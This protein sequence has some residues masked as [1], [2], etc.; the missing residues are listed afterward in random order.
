M[1]V[2]PVWGSPGRRGRELLP[3]TPVVSVTDETAAVVQT[4]LA[5]GRRRLRVVTEVDTA[6]RRTPLLL[7]HLD[8]GAEDFVLLSGHLDSWHRGAMDNGSA[9]AT[10]MEV[11]RVLAGRREALPRGLLVAFWSGHSHGRY[12]GSAW[13]ADERCAELSTRCVAHVNVDSVGGRGATQI[14]RGV[15]TAALRGLGAAVIRELTGDE[16]TGTRVGRAG[17]QSFL[18]HG[19]PSLWMSL[20]EQPDGGLGWWWH[21]TEDT[22]DK[23]DPDLLLRDARI[24]AL[25]VARLVTCP[26]LPLDAAA[27]AGEVADR[28]GA[29]AAAAGPDGFDLA[30]ATARAAELAALAADLELRRPQA[31]RLPAAARAFDRAIVATLR[32]LVAAGY[33][34]AG[35]WEPDP[36]LAVPPLPLL[37]PVQGLADLPPDSDEARFLR[38]D[39]TRARNRVVAALET[40]LAAARTGLAELGSIE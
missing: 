5:A 15:T 25:A 16:F 34:T 17:D 11:A 32:P 21:T 2:S 12:S 35:P 9:N 40:A 1:I 8:G 20:S 18:G 23:I 31:D 14:G 37:D 10:M 13:F 4:H 27:E 19:V 29:L 38:V 24:Y 22:V 7:A 30:P 6:W 26:T 39:M 3:R 36:A 28:L 33:T